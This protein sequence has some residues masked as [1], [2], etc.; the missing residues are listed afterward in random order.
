[1]SVT[2]DV[3]NVEG[4]KISLIDQLKAQ[5]LGFLQQK[6]FAQNNLNQLIG[7]I[8]ACEQMIKHHENNVALQ[9]NQTDDL[10]GQGDGGTDDQTQEQAT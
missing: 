3:L 1:M 9:S 10:G 6:E 4:P 8:F 2:Q 5:H 7:A